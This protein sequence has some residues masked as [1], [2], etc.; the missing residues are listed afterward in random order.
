MN[1]IGSYL[2]SCLKRL[3]KSIRLM[4][5]IDSQM[6]CFRRLVGYFHTIWHTNAV[7]LLEYAQRPENIDTSHR[8]TR[9]SGFLMRYKAIGT[10]HLLCKLSFLI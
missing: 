8:E 10:Q 2:Q 7:K 1:R 3:I 9:A 5:I 6:M 4:A